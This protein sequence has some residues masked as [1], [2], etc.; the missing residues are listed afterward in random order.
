MIAQRTR[1][2][3]HCAG[4]LGSAAVEFAMTAPLLIVLALGIADYGVLI[5]CRAWRL[6]A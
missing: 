3:H 2:F 1:A 4:E 5:T 6:G